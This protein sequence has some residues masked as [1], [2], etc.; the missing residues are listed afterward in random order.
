M[1]NLEV[2]THC[3]T[4]LQYATTLWHCSR[5]D[6]FLSIRS[7]QLGDAALCP[8]CGEVAL[9]FCG[10]LSNIPWVQFGDA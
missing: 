1:L 10:K 8:V 5:C 6:A 7:T 4:V 2:R 9:E 3:A